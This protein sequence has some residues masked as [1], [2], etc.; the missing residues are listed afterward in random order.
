MSF[1]ALSRVEN[2]SQLSFRIVHDISMSDILTSENVWFSSSAQ[3][4]PVSEEA[5]LVLGHWD[6]AD[7]TPEVSIR[8]SSNL[9]LILSASKYF[10]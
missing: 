1:I 10:R 2:W 7:V 3:L 6:T 5:G 4:K 8:D 9:P